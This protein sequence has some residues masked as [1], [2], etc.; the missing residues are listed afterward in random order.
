[1][2]AAPISVFLSCA[3]GAGIVFDGQG[4]IIYTADTE[5]RRAFVS[6]GCLTLGDVAQLLAELMETFGENDISLALS[7]ALISRRMQETEDE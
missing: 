7:I 2:N 6:A 4:A 5:N 3:D 1:M